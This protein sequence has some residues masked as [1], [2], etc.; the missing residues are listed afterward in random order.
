MNKL[1]VVDLDL[2]LADTRAIVQS[3]GPE[4]TPGTPE[5]EQWVKH[6]T[7]P[8]VLN[9]APLVPWTSNILDN[10]EYAHGRDA[11]V[12]ITNRRESMRPLTQQWLTSHGF[13]SKLFM[14]PEGDLRPAGDFKASV[15]RSLVTKDTSVLVLDDDPDFSIARVC[16]ENGWTHFKLTN[17]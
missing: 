1:I 6:V 14:R 17:Y 5:H 12:F 3:G 9:S 7:N 16:K 2:T 10:L 4:P 11:I 8:E 15:I 13:R